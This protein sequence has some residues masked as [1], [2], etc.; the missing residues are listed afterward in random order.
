MFVPVVLSAV[1]SFLYFSEGIMV[2]FRGALG[3]S[4]CAMGAAL[5]RMS[6][7]GC[8]ICENAATACKIRG[9]STNPSAM[10]GALK[11]HL[12]C[13]KCGKETRGF[14][15][16]HLDTWEHLDISRRCERLR[17]AFEQVLRSE[18]S[19]IR[20]RA[21]LERL[22][23]SW[24]I[25]SE[26]GRTCL[27]G[28]VAVLNVPH[29]LGLALTF[30]LLGMALIPPHLYL[31]CVTVVTHGRARFM[32][33]LELR[34][35]IEGKATSAQEDEPSHSPPLPPSGELTTDGQ[36][37]R[38]TRAWGVVTVL[39]KA[40][41]VYLPAAVAATIVAAMVLGALATAAA[42][43]S[44]VSLTSPQT[45]VALLRRTLRVVL[46]SQLVDISVMLSKMRRDVSID[47]IMQRERDKQESDETTERRS[48]LGGQRGSLDH[49][50]SEAEFSTAP[51][52]QMDTVYSAMMFVFF[53][54]WRLPMVALHDW[55]F[56]SWFCPR[57]PMWVIS[58]RAGAG[59]V[60]LQFGEAGNKR[61]LQE[62]TPEHVQIR[63]T[64]LSAGTT[65]DET[66]Q[67]TGTEEKGGEAAQP[68]EQNGM[69]IDL[70]LIGW[71]DKRLSAYL[72]PEDDHEDDEL[73]SSQ[74][75]NLVERH[76]IGPAR[77]SESGPTNSMLTFD[78]AVPS[79]LTRLLV[80]GVLQLEYTGSVG[81]R[82][83]SEHW[84]FEDWSKSRELA[85]WRQIVVTKVDLNLKGQDEEES[86][87]VMG[88]E[89]E[90]ALETAW[91]DAKPSEEESVTVHVIL[92]AQI[93]AQLSDGIADNSANLDEQS[94]AAELA[95]L[96]ITAR[97]PW[98]IKTESAKDWRY[99]E[100]WNVLLRRAVEPLKPGDTVMAQRPVDRVIEESSAKVRNTHHKAIGK[101]ST[102]AV[103][104]GTSVWLSRR[105]MLG[106][107]KGSLR[108]GE[109]GEVVAIDHAPNGRAKFQ[110]RGPTGVIDWYDA[111]D[112]EIQTP[113][114][115]WNSLW[116]LAQVSQ[117]SSASGAPCPVVKLKFA[118]D[119][120]RE[121]RADY[122]AAEYT[123]PV[124]RVRSSTPAAHEMRATPLR[125]DKSA[126]VN[127]MTSCTQMFPDFFL[128][129]NEG[130]FRKTLGRKI[131][132]AIRLLFRSWTALCG[133]DLSALY[134]RICKLCA[135]R[136]RVDESEEDE[137][138]WKQYA[139]DKL[140]ELKH[141]CLQHLRSIAKVSVV[142]L[143]ILVLVLVPTARPPPVATLLFIGIVLLGG[144]A[145]VDFSEGLR[146]GRLLFAATVA[147][148]LHLFVGLT[149]FW[150]CELVLA[151][152]ATLGRLR[153]LI[154]SMLGFGAVKTGYEVLETIAEF[155]SQYELPPVPIPYNKGDRVETRLKGGTR[156]YASRVSKVNRDGTYDVRYLRYRVSG[157]TFVANVGT[158][159]TRH[160]LNLLPGE[161]IEVKV[162]QADERR[163]RS[164]KISEASSDGQPE[165]VR[166]QRRVRVTFDD[167]DGQPEDVEAKDARL[168]EMSVDG[169]LIRTRGSASDNQDFD[170][171]TESVVSDSDVEADADTHMGPALGPWANRELF[172]PDKDSEDD[173]P[174]HEWAMLDKVL[175]TRPQPG[176]TLRLPWPYPNGT[177]FKN[178]KVIKHRRES[179]LV[180][181]DAAYNVGDQVEIQRHLFSARWLRGTI[182]SRP[183]GVSVE[184]GVQLDDGGDELP[185]MPHRMRTVRSNRCWVPFAQLHD[186][187]LERYEEELVLASVQRG[188]LR[189]RGQVRAK[190]LCRP[191][192]D[193][194]VRGAIVEEFDDGHSALLKFEH[195]KRLDKLKIA[196]LK[197]TIHELRELRN[198]I[199]RKRKRRNEEANIFEA[200]LKQLFAKSR[201][202]DR[203]IDRLLRHKELLDLAK[204]S[205]S[206]E[207]VEAL[208]R[209][210]SE[211]LNEDTWMDTIIKAGMIAADHL[212]KRIEPV[213]LKAGWEKRD[214][215]F[216]TPQRSLMGCANCSCRQQLI[217]ERAWKEERRRPK[218]EMMTEDI[219]R[220]EMK[221]VVEAFICDV[222]QTKERGELLMTEIRFFQFLCAQ[223]VSL[224]NLG[225]HPCLD[226]SEPARTE[227]P[228]VYKEP[229][230][231]EVERHLR[232]HPEEIPDP[233]TSS[234]SAAGVRKDKY[235]S[236]GVMV[237][238]F[239][240][241]VLSKDALETIDCSEQE[242]GRH[243]LDAMPAI[244]CVPDKTLGTGV[245]Y[246]DQTGSAGPLMVCLAACL[247]AA[248]LCG[249]GWLG[250]LI[251]EDRRAKDHRKMSA[252]K[253]VVLGVLALHMVAAA[254]AFTFI[255][256]RA[257]GDG[258]PLGSIALSLGLPYATLIP[259]GV[260][261][262]ALEVQDDKTRAEPAFRSKFG[263]L[264]LKYRAGTQREYGFPL[265][266]GWEVTLMF[267]KLS[268][269]VVQMFTSG[270]AVASTAAGEYE[271]PLNQVT[272]AFGVLFAFC[273]LHQAC[274][275]YLEQSLNMMD[276]AC[277]MSHIFVCFAGTMVRRVAT[278]IFPSILQQCVPISHLTHTRARA[279]IYFLL[280]RYTRSF[281]QVAWR[282]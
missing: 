244:D 41:V 67:S 173:E 228:D 44:A 230:V 140:L 151:L 81:K 80:F 195:P 142:V 39:V 282:K 4:P 206:D 185:V 182:R 189:V 199:K 112:L 241:L 126:N 156:W 31:L 98:P 219:F 174:A 216:V 280:S 242:T 91:D 114:F 21:E 258:I 267:R 146:Q 165:G 10:S 243:S 6:P 162:V 167:G 20:G 19:R 84:R 214:S 204:T 79:H 247:A 198:K 90:G 72:Q 92:P 82:G 127:L 277:L 197:N 239:A 269:G 25:E 225:N 30:T 261:W 200:N 260:C 58:T 24:Q 224:A 137:T 152:V 132:R 144:V 29:V 265:F 86:T 203:T 186:G 46:P 12:K 123:V 166:S 74:N 274:L 149:I 171:D 194:H 237:G 37:S 77:L 121:S 202:R 158:E 128:S 63:L 45:V 68:D 235:L 164:G 148:C 54:A 15:L 227:A 176:D 273:V 231:H 40:L 262:C 5:V 47:Q 135:R 279:R 221:P 103:E 117:N 232:E 107:R 106:L 34:F 157:R 178:A 93:R 259:L 62:W 177:E 50:G 43:A 7:C 59:E 14:A 9:Q 119:I 190:Q 65:Q 134:A 2:Q 83:A 256:I 96:P 179:C 207:A 172:G 217:L 130:G 99:H 246:A 181:F 270:S 16:L 263:Y 278:V 101:T 1:L 170:S 3:I 104:V 51:V 180:Q 139:V 229:D 131:F 85:D 281:F 89:E 61:T 17:C 254:A 210:V 122:T 97:L 115:V 253:Y 160:E 264:F 233:D 193:A 163:W 245:R 100:Q 223:I 38:R 222:H 116:E 145:F 88:E 55:L 70:V 108:L 143:V 27:S 236:A 33:S 136:S 250:R 71:V 73:S 87:N 94:E 102:S 249:L 257:S 42:F 154:S 226:A 13:I 113:P 211:S 271:Q 109:R 8:V 22:G 209:C 192:S 53:A 125:I 208:S 48:S 32:Q 111:A 255:A 220:Q 129:L 175:T 120:E 110:I 11:D 138:D 49:R 118:A 124:E 66:E 168:L 60:T 76:Y 75:P 275:P 272:V 213:S 238:S 196:K 234:V 56:N 23:A 159:P 141:V 18:T 150:G 266:F 215:T 69:P 252:G 248:C 187:A 26:R 183:R 153:F 133:E 36:N 28:V 78:D 155:A 147:L 212:E 64:E 105:S 201:D 218:T 52:A 184:Y 240:H 251:R 169:H 268:V 57:A 276:T 95:E 35:D 161:T 205:V 191:T 188:T